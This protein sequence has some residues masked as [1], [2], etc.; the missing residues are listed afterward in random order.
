[1]P[2]PSRGRDWPRSSPT[3]RSLLTRGHTKRSFWPNRA[4][5]S[6]PPDKVLLPEHI[7]RL[8]PV[9]ELRTGRPS[10]RAAVRPR[11]R[12]VP[13]FCIPFSRCS[14]FAS[15]AR[16]I[17]A[18]NCVCN[19]GH[20]VSVGTLPAY[21][22]AQKAADQSWNNRYVAC[23]DGGE[24]LCGELAGKLVGNFADNL[25]RNVQTLVQVKV[26]AARLPALPGTKW[27]I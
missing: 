27:S 20:R 21:K 17:S 14:A 25:E 4:S 23:A 7:R 13:F 19:S 18:G 3:W 16:S 12:P 8:H 22:H 1:M 5:T 10:L 2:P 6:A 15:P 24:S 26:P 11:P 9:Q